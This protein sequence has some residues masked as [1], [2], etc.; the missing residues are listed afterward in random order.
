[1]YGTTKSVVQNILSSGRIC[2]L[3][4]DIQG[5]ENLKKMPDFHPIYIFIKPPSVEELKARL[6]KRG[7]ETEEQLQKRFATAKIDLV[8]AQMH[9]DDFDFFLVNDDFDQAYEQLEDMMEKAFGAEI[10]KSAAR[11]LRIKYRKLSEA[12]RNDNLSQIRKCACEVFG[13]DIDDGP[14]PQNEIKLLKAIAK[15]MCDE[16]TASAASVVG[17]ERKFSIFFECRSILHKY[18]GDDNDV[19]WQDMEYWSR[20]V[21]VDKNGKCHLFPSNKKNFNK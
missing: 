12:C 19:E 20:K 14:G 21:V 7:T 2:I 16:N 8:K 10:I 15:R 9:L 3:D 17:L 6:C 18:S 5:V 13:P 1:M 4:V 11:D